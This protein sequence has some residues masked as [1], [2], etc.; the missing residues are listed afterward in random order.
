[1]S[2]SQLQEVQVAPPHIACLNDAGVRT[3]GICFP[4]RGQHTLLTLMPHLFF[5][6]VP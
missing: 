5:A 3:D 1:L 2:T 4:Q 6:I